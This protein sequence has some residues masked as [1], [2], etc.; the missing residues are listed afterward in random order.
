MFRQEALLPA[1]LLQVKY[2]GSLHALLPMSQ[3][4][5]CSSSLFFSFTSGLIPLPDS[6]GE[7]GQATSPLIESQTHCSFFI[8]Q[9][10]VLPVTDLPLGLRSERTRETV[11]HQDNN[12]E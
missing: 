7:S 6:G 3:P 5:S 10:P 8:C 12:R 4:D 9:E 2:P 1:I 11:S